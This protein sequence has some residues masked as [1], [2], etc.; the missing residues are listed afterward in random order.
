MTRYK[1]FNDIKTYWYPSSKENSNANLIYL[2]GNKIDLINDRTVDENE[3]R[4]Y[5]EQNNIRYF[6]ISCKTYI[7]LNEFFDDLVNEL[8][9]I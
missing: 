7:G 4:N 2:L 1:S 9:K 3:A 6:E 8:I 5:A